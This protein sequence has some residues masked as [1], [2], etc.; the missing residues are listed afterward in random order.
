M[1]VMIGNARIAETGG[2]NGTRGDQTGKEV[3]TQTW[4]SGGTWTYVFRAKSDAVA[5]K[6]ANAMK[7]ACANNNIGYS[8]SDR[9][10]LYNIVSK[11]GWN[12]G[13]A[14]KCNCDCSSLVAVCVNAA[15]IRVSADM[16]TGNE[17]AIL[18]ASGA[19]T[20]Y[21]AAAYTKQ[22]GNLMTGD[23]LLRAG[24]TAIVTQGISRGS[25]AATPAKKSLDAVAAD[26]RAGKFGNGDQR[27]AAL[28]RAG[29]SD[30]E[31]AQI[32]A[33]VNALVKK[34]AAS[35]VSRPS[36]DA[37]ARDIIA[38]KYGN[39]NARVAKLKALGFSSSEVAQIQKRVNDLLS[40]TRINAAVNDV[41]QG[42][43]GN[44]ATRRQKLLSSGF[45]SAEIARIQALVNQRLR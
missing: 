24:H 30:A 28:K 9:R 8:Q 7:A 12:I 35:P 22:A 41:L 40:N 15:G 31:I 17:K 43:Y 45:T 23:I 27:K 16:Y 39:G 38:G 29:Y 32:Q 5:N 44:G 37:A 13:G 34:P 21:S 14:G 1:A 25:S 42:K 20:T 10:S 3:M 26:V 2:V 11:N 36:I 18:E 4:S 19:F 6:I 33:K